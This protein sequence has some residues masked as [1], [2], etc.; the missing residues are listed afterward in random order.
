M[1]LNSPPIFLRSSRR[2]SPSLWQSTSTWTTVSAPQMPRSSARKRCSLP[3]VASQ[4]WPVRSCVSRYSRFHG[5]DPYS[6]RVR[7]EGRVLSIWRRCSPVV[8]FAHSSFHSFRIF[9][10]MNPFSRERRCWK[11]CIFLGPTASLASRSPSSFPGS[12]QC[13]GTRWR[14]IGIPRAFISEAACSVA[15]II[16]WPDVLDGFRIACSADMLSLRI[17]ASRL[18]M[19]RAPRFFRDI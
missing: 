1:L 14:R 17:V 8:D 12:P 13:P 16:L 15:R 2:R 5:S 11:G 7:I 9:F 6:L 18:T 3:Y 10:P 4:E 19:P